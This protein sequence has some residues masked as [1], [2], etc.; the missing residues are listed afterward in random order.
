MATQ[1][2]LPQLRRRTTADVMSVFHK[3]L[4]DLKRVKDQHNAEAEKQRQIAAEAQAAA[5]EA[6]T[7]A[8]KAH[9]V[10]AKLETLVN[11]E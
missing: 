5:L 6:A 10:A 8:E 11:A 7:E 1:L 4:A 3:T 9:N 2:A